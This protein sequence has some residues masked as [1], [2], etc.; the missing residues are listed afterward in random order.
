MCK[1]FL[2]PYWCSGS[3]LFICSAFK[4]KIVSGSS[5]NHAVVMIDK[6]KI[7]LYKVVLGTME[8]EGVGGNL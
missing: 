8:E 4:N 6:K 7:H 5:W 3:E 2:S 1:R